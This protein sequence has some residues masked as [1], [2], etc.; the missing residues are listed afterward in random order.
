MQRETCAS[1]LQDAMIQCLY[2]ESQT[3]TSIVVVVVVVVVV[4]SVV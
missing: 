1:S 2:T 4:V 3:F